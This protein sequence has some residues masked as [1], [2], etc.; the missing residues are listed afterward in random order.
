MN[1][2]EMVFDASWEYLVLPLD[3]DGWMNR[4]TSP[5][6]LNETLNSAGSQ[7]WELVTMTNW[8]LVTMTNVATSG[9]TSQLLALFKRQVR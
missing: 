4:T 5:S 8:E 2:T 7:G 9:N 1:H 6:D 3:V